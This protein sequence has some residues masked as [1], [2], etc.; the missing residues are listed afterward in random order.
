MVGFCLND[1][2]LIY[3]WSPIIVLEQSVYYCCSSIYIAVVK[4][5]YLSVLAHLRSAAGR[6]FLDPCTVRR[7]STGAPNLVVRKYSGNY[8]G[9][10]EYIRYSLMLYLVRVTLGWVIDRSSTPILHS[11]VGNTFTFGV[12][13]RN[14]RFE[15]FFYRNACVRG[16]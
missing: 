11:S 16:S 10:P 6:N 12:V 13:G 7:T 3:L 1:T 8:P 2:V 4:L 5:S 15:R 9:S 14:T